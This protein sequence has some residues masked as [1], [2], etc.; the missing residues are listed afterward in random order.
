ME[1]RKEN[2]SKEEDSL[3]KSQ[4]NFYAFYRKFCDLK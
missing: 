1:T 3:S 4:E 2:K